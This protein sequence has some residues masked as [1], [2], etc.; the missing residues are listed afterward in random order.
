[1]TKSIAQTLLE[2]QQAWSRDHFRREPGPGTNH[3]PGEEPFPNVQSELLLPQLHSVMPYGAVA[4]LGGNAPA[5]HPQ[6][7][8]G[9]PPAP[10]SCGFGWE[11]CGATG[12]EV[13]LREA[14]LRA[15][16]LP[17]TLQ[18]SGAE[19]HGAQGAVGC[20]V[21]KETGHFGRQ[22]KG[23]L[24]CHCSSLL[25]HCFRRKTWHLAAS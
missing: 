10:G 12:K 6:G 21:R 3:P 5:S 13:A 17:W 18:I 14:P 7:H 23:H 9:S 24:S 1:M 4:F 11:G 25:I 19:N 8:G 22:G 16:G 15:L 20:W 2:P